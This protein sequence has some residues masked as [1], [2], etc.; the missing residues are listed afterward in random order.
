MKHQ[1]SSPLR[2]KGLVVSGIVVAN[3][4]RA[5][6]CQTL[7]IR[8][9]LSNRPRFIPGRNDGENFSMIDQLGAVTFFLGTEN[10]H[11][12]LAAGLATTGAARLLGWR[13]FLPLA[14]LFWV[15]GWQRMDRIQQQILHGDS[16][17]PAMALAASTLERAGRHVCLSLAQTPSIQGELERLLRC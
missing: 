5:G 2:L 15:L 12:L 11:L 14:V 6:Q 1:G 17:P 16:R 3:H 13:A 10:V 7:D 4:N 8:Y 9:G